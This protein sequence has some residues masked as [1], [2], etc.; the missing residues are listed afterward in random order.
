MLARCQHRVCEFAS[1]LLFAF[2]LGT[3]PMNSSD[4]RWYPC[5]W[6]G[7]G[8]GCARPVLRHILVP[9][10]GPTL[11]QQVLEPAV[12]LGSLMQEDYTLLHIYGISTDLV[13]P[14]AYSLAG[15]HRPKRLTRTGLLG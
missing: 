10:V 12:A 1:H 3:S 5:F 9:L 8:N 13:D 14:M 7:L 6:Y 2:G 15:A 11:S 4:G